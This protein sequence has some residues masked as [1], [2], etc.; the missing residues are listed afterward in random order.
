VGAAVSW[1]SI[2][3]SA[4]MMPNVLPQPVC[5]RCSHGT[6]SGTGTS[7]VLEPLN[8]TGTLVCTAPDCGQEYP[9]IDGI[10]I[11]ARDVRGWMRANHADLLTRTDLDE[12]A[13]SLIGDCLDQTAPYNLSRQHLSIYAADHY[14]TDLDA[15][16]G[17]SVHDIL[18][19][20]LAQ[21][22]TLPDGAVV[23]M[24]CAVGGTTFALARHFPQRA[25]LGLDL[26]W[27]MLS[28][29]RRALDTGTVNYPLREVGL[30]YR[31]CT[32]MVARD[33]ALPAGFWLADAIA[34]P[35]RPGS[36]ALVVAL[37]LLDCVNDPPGL[38]RSIA[39]LL[40]PGGVCLLATPF[41]WSA[42]ATPIEGWIGGHSQR[43]PDSGRA[44]ARFRLMIDGV[45]LKLEAEDDHPWSLRLHARS[46]VDYL[47]ALFVL[48]KPS[49]ESLGD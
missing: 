22:G 41:D 33:G 25:V 2:Q 3:R 34:P 10:P 28:L 8:A 9:V 32:R 1:N 13:K 30:V 42:N 18:A 11:L 44:E 38:L 19:A 31:D 36:A 16:K 5:P 17:Q 37:N 15:I 39:S 48:R 40:A 20:G 27:S 7:R 21:C 26:S 12:T 47:S 4:G 23:D 43:A 46:R 45:G 24:G 6:G 35:L 14:G 49:S 29:A